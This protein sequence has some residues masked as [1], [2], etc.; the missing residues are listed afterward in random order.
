[1]A[2]AGGGGGDL[3]VLQN[4]CILWGKG[5]FGTCGASYHQKNLKFKHDGTTCDQK[6]LRRRKCVRRAIFRNVEVRVRPLHP[7]LCLKHVQLYHCATC[8]GSSYT[9]NEYGLFY[10]K[11]DTE[12]FFI[13]QFFRN[14]LYFQ[15]KPQ[16]TWQFF[17]ERRRLTLKISITFLSQMRYRVFYYLPIFSKNV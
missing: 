7:S 2:L 12:Y 1:M 15:R 4:I 6:I 8:Q 11:F 5:L 9:K 13:P 14:K 10:Q 16:K 3:R 17:R